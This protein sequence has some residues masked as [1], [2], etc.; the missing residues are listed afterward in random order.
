MVYNKK[1]LIDDYETIQSFVSH[2]FE[3]QYHNVLAKPSRAND[4]LSWSV[5]DKDT[6]KGL[7]ELNEKDK[8]TALEQY[9]GL[10][11]KITEKLNSP[12]TSEGAAQ[13]KNIIASVFA[14]ENVEIFYD[15]EEIKLA[16]GVQ[17]GNHD[18]NAAPFKEEPKEEPEAEEGAGLAALAATT[19]PAPK[20]K[21][22]LVSS[23]KERTRSY[24]IFYVFFYGIWLFIKRYWSLLLLALLAIFLLH[25]CS[26]DCED[27]NNS[28]GIPNRDGDQE[29]VGEGFIPDDERVRPPID[30]TQ[31]IYDDSSMQQIVPDRINIALKDRN[32]SIKTFAF[33]LKQEY[34][35]ST[36]KI[37]YIDTETG[38]LQ[39]QFPDTLRAT[40]KDD[41]K[42]KM[43]A[44]DLLIWDESIFAFSRTFND[45]AF[46]NTNQSYYFNSV[47]APGAWN[48]TTGD[49]DI[50]VAV[51]D[52]GFDLNHP[53][54]K[55][56]NIVK[57]Y[58]L[59]NKDDK[60]Y[61][62]Y[63][64]QHGTHVSATI[65]GEN[66]N[67]FGSSGIAPDCSF[68]PIQLSMNDGV[69]TNTDVIDGILY[70]IKHGAD[71]INLS[72]GRVFSPQL[73][74]LPV[75]EQERLIESMG[76]DE[77]EF[78]NELYDYAKKENVTIVY[79]GG[80]DN[81]LIGID[82]MTR[83]D[84]V[85]TVSAI[86]AANQ[87]AVFSNYGDYSTISAPGVRIYNALPGSKMDYMDGT[88]M[89][90]PIVTG[91]VALMKSV[92][93]DLTTEE[94]I[95]IL[96]ATAK[97]LYVANIGPLIQIEAALKKI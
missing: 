25:Y 70:A 95:K 67:G 88:S 5:T 60:V 78:W 39:F 68:M 9:H 24:N 75:A 1:L 53:E 17:F 89:A 40:I 32:K 6:Y 10:R 8:N 42:A 57:P 4:Y 96:D 61:A 49:K 31:L 36:Y 34:P 41:I 86:D 58:N 76:I 11:D 71:V 56:A 84:L 30:T 79:A 46:S 87:K 90:A 85:I 66:D 44:Y 77:A 48:I 64:L 26:P 18:K 3:E 82:P 15:G 38:R 54:L 65:I 27:N 62:N 43:T 74:S 28:N 29:E 91:A 37:I 22:I 72:L 33:K 47:Q 55:N 19:P 35:D 16:W 52:D 83:S 50:I 12:S 21:H 20:E 2:N 51:V 45:P 97:S 7:H 69:I 93:P 92:D 59:E 13:W 81:V 14:P 73:T 63:D 94:I 23:Q 80:N